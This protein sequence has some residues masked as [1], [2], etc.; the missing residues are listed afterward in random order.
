MDPDPKPDRHD[1]GKPVGEGGGKSN[2][3]ENAPTIDEDATWK[4]SAY[5][6]TEHGSKDKGE[7]S[8][9]K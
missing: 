5:F 6:G 7:G 3:S 4:D 2:S 1:R 8:Q 9:E